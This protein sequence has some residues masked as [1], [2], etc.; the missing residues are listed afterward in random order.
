MPPLTPW[1][2]LLL[3]FSRK[4]WGSRSCSLASL[5]LNSEP[6]CCLI[7]AL[8][9][10]NMTAIQKRAA[11]LLFIHESSFSGSSPLYLD[12]ISDKGAG[13]PIICLLMLA[14]SAHICC[15]TSRCTGGR[16]AHC[17]MPA[18]SLHPR[19]QDNSPGSHVPAPAGIATLAANLQSRTG[20]LCFSG[21]QAHRAEDGQPDASP[22]A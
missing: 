15:C 1:A 12:N 21:K 2:L 4:I 14:K 16:G 13:A 19:S 5:G 18:A 10:L 6:C 7:L 22:H 8:G 11:L 17:D 3:F 20:E 9:Q